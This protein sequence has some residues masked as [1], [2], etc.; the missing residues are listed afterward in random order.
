MG[1]K[2]AKL[3]IMEAKKK[4]VAP[5]FKPG[6]FKSEGQKSTLRPHRR[7]ILKGVRSKLIHVKIFLKVL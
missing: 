3:E 1:T 2:I 7:L 5:I 6:T 4:L